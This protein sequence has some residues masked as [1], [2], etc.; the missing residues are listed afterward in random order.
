M[1]FSNIEAKETPEWKYPAPVAR[2][3]QYLKS[4][5]D[6]FKGMEPGIYPLEGR[7]IFVQV[8]DVMTKEKAEARPEVHR[9][10]IEIHY[11][12]E[13]KERIGFAV[14]L[15]SNA[16]TET[17]LE[18]KDAIFYEGADR[19]AELVLAPGDYAVFFPEDVHRPIWEHGGSVLIRRVVIK[20]DQAV[21]QK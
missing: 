10:Y 3:V 17:L 8:F 9:K 7:D 21:M 14:D 4:H 15:G 18:T 13:G 5:R 16:V 20:I 1:F 19:E 6:E 11:S 2:A 12:V